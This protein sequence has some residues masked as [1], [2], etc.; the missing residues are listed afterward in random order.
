MSK[1]RFDTV[2]PSYEG[3]E[4]GPTY[5]GWVSP[6]FTFEVANEIL[7]NCYKYLFFFNKDEDTFIIDYGTFT[8]QFK[9]KD[10]TIDGKT[11]HLYPIGSGEWTWFE[12][13]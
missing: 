2:G 4:I 10:Y 12:E 1:Y 9:G 3:Y 8:E 6:A 7:K 11:I 5:N 13:K